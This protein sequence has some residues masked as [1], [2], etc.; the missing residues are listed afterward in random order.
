[1]SYSPGEEVICVDNS[2][3]YF[4]GEPSGLTCGKTY[5]VLACLPG[6]RPFTHGPFISVTRHTIWFSYKRF[7]KPTASEEKNETKEM[8]PA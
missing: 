2:P 6:G 7:R 5:V 3:G 1:M 4:T 8:E